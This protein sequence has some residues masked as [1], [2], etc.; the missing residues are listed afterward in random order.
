MVSGVRLSDGS[1]GRN[2]RTL[3]GC[4][5]L[6]KPQAWHGINALA[7]CMESPKAYG[8]TRQRV[9]SCALIRYNTACWWYTNPS[10]LIIFLIVWFSLH[11]DKKKGH[12]CDVL[13]FLHLIYSSACVTVIRQMCR[14]LTASQACASCGR[15]SKPRRGRNREYHEVFQTSETTHYEHSE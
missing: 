3:F 11:R 13:S 15:Y 2:I 14:L 4:F 12:P 8:I 7:H 5:F 10:D 1:P 9:F 6:S